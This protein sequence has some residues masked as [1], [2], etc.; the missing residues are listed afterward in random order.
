MNVNYMMAVMHQEIFGL[1]IPVRRVASDGEAIELTNDSDYGLTASTWTKDFVK[2]GELMLRLE[3]R[4][5]CI[6]WYDYRNPTL[7]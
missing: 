7:A 2:G 4:T 1:V 5:A 6:N 3:S